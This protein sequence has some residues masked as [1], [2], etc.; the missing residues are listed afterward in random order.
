MCL[1]TSVLFKK[2]QSCAWEASTSTLHPPTFP[3]IERFV[4]AYFVLGFHTFKEGWHVLLPTLCSPFTD[5][6]TEA[7]QVSDLPKFTQQVSG[8]TRM[9]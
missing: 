8:R 2:Q 6:E 9:K 3:T 4:L 7:W 1:E 5:G